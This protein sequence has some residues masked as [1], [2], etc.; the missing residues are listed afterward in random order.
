MPKRNKFS[1]VHSKTKTIREIA[2][3]M[4]VYRALW[5]LS[6]RNRR[7]HLKALTGATCD[8]DAS[9]CESD[10]VIRDDDAIA[11]RPRL[12]TSSTSSWVRYVP[13]ATIPLARSVAF[14]TTLEFHRSLACLTPTRRT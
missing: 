6:P 8:G 14:P 10:E 3:A 7:L 12:I 5:T 4:G 2:T 13:E 1:N 11:R 9:A